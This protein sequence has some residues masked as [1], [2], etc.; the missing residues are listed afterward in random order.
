MGKKKV[1]GVLV[2]GIGDDFT[3]Q[4]CRGVMQAARQKDVNVVI[5]PG[6][7]IKRNVTDS[8]D[9]MYEYQYNT[10]F[11]YALEQRFDALLITAGSIC[12]YADETA[13]QKFLNAFESVPCILIGDKR[14]GFLSVNYDNYN[15]IKEGLEYLIGQLNCQRIVMVGGPENNTDAME[16]KRTFCSV[17]EQNG[18]EVT[19]E[20]YI[21]GNLTRKQR[22][23]L[24]KYLEKHPDVEA[25]CCVN[26]DTAL[27]VYEALKERGLEPGKDV[28]VMGY[29]NTLQGAKTKPS[30]S[31]VMADALALGRKALELALEVLSGKEAGNVVVPTKFIKRESF[32]S[33]KM[34]KKDAQL[35]RLDASYIDSYFDEI[36]YRYVMEGND[37]R[38]RTIFH[39]IMEMVIDSYKAQ[40]PLGEIYTEGA[41]SKLIEAFLRMGAL[42]YADVENLLIHVEEISELMMDKSISSSRVKK[43]FATI[44]EI[45]RNMI[46]SE[47]QHQGNQFDMQDQKNY[48]LKMFVT[49]SMQFEKGN[50]QSYEVLLQNLDWLDIK[51]AILYTYEKPMV[52]LEEENF[53]VPGHLYVKA[54]LCQNGVQTTFGKQQ[55]K[56]SKELFRN[57]LSQEGS[58]VKVLLPLFANEVLYGVLLCDM[59]EKLFENGEFLAGQ[60][61]VAAKMLHILKQNEDIQNQYEESMVVLKENNIA[62][63]ALAK[64]DGLTGSLNRRGFTEEAAKQLESYRREN[65]NTLV[66]YIDMN[67]LKIINDR[68]GHDEGDF[69]IQLIGRMLKETF[70]GGIIGRIGGDEFALLTAYTGEDITEIRYRLYNAFRVFNEGSDKAYN[71][72]VSA[73]FYVVDSA[74]ET[75][76]S[77]A[78]AFADERLYVEKQNRSKTVAKDPT[79]A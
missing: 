42:E 62:L 1:I 30:L 27:G 32:G 14:P 51:H 6:K 8:K 47:E 65:K 37:N 11:S 70:P 12:C 69:S 63:D 54:V 50:S 35:K 25:F 24:L 3:V 49:K 64:S 21:E 79:E 13:N 61:G 73:G 60:L 56:R 41:L 48:D 2:S 16:R 26:D 17:M 46:I 36:F 72:M 15:G 7:Y 53:V 77:D 78:L 31:T 44:S 59:S 28:Y 34:K 4:T 29:D 38:L 66:A 76:L 52:H 75:E 71:V 19:S 43:T 57:S 22:E 55:R 58:Q 67:N 33:E 9:L 68:Y 5:I 18:I 45:Y 40:E 10:L 74:C 39:T 23:D 20:N